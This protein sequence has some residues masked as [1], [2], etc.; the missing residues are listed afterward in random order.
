MTRPVVL[1]R[2]QENGD[3]LMARQS[4]SAGVPYE[5]LREG[6]PVDLA[7]GRTATVKKAVRRSREELQIFCECPPRVQPK[8]KSTRR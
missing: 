2:D 8:V 5:S 7:D 1:F 3:Y 6:D 4:P